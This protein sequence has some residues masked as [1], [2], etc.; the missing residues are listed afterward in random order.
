MDR[1][2]FLRSSAV[3]AGGLW[4][5]TTACVPPPEFVPGSNGTPFSS[6]V[7]SGLHSPTE[8][9]LWT[10]L[11]PELA[12][13]TG[14]VEWQ[15]AT[16]PT[17]SSVVET[18]SV[19]VGPAADHTA[20]VLVG[21]LRP[22][23]SYAYRFV[24][25]GV[26][27]PAGRARTLPLRDADVDRLRLA[28]TSCQ[29]WTAGWYQAWDAIA[30]ADLDAVL[31][32][33]D[34]IYEGGGTS[35]LIAVRPDTVGLADTLDTYRAKYRMY[36]SDLSLQGAHAAHPLVPVWDDHEFTNNFDRSTVASQPTR[37]A[38]AA[39][40]WFEY[41]PVW[42]IDGTRIHRN[43]EWGRLAQVSMLDTRQ[44]RDRPANGFNPDPDADELF[45]GVGATVVEAVSPGRTILGVDQREWFLDS[46]ADASDRDV[47]WKLVGNQVMISPIRALDLDNEV[48]RTLNPAIPEHD[49][50]YIN[51]DSW[52][53]YLWE[54]DL[55]LDHLRS[56]NIENVSFVTGDVHFFAQSSMRSDFDDD[57]SPFVANEFVGGSI[58]SPGPNGAR[59][60]ALGLELERLVTNL[61]PGF[62]HVDFR[63][64]G[65]GVVDLT[66]G[67][68]TV[69]FWGTQAWNRGERVAPTV[70]FDQ[71]AGEPRPTRT[72]L[73]G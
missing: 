5:G 52:H 30:T 29:A 56:G 6:G 49:G 12:A 73:R 39:Q 66:P 48:L 64:N 19:D 2:T 54:R 57:S 35:G 61:S 9:V 27:S 69:T 11:D 32:L 59:T 20:K 41:M 47:T 8:V 51:L 68:Q 45:I 22:D 37:F 53:S 33:G 17:F 24:V 44:F 72:V 10:R 36:R 46:L 62:R 18:G 16:D 15:V 63:R 42:P 60:D 43:V 38:A 3:G 25:D 34:Y 71:I 58:S 55:I 23:T 4:L 1:R 70:R 50:V 26:A 7:A 67:S 13:G 65:F 21:G 31:F 28:F 40:A 14:R